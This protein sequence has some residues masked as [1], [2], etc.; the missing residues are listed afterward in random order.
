LIGAVS[1]PGAARPSAPLR[2]ALVLDLMPRKLGSVER[3]VI[4]TVREARRRGHAI[5]VFTR[6]PVHRAI[7]EQLAALGAA[8]GSVGP[9]ERPGQ[10]I[11]RLR[12]YDVVEYHFVGARSRL[13][14][15]GCA[16][17][18]ARI[19]LVE[20]NS[21]WG[22][23]RTLADRLRLWILNGVT[24]P[25]I[26][27]LIGVSDYARART[28]RALGFPLERTATI[29]NGVD[30]ELFSPPPPP[31]PSP[32]LPVQAL[33]PRGPLTVLAVAHFI[34]EKGID[35]LLRAL[36]AV[37][38]VTARLLLV[39]DGPEEPRLRRLTDELGLADRVQFGGLR[40]D[41][42]ALLR[43]ADVFVHPATWQEAFGW[44]IAEAMASGCA[45]IA[46]SVG[47]IP[48]LIEHDRSGL[49]VPPADP[50]ALAQAI[51]RLADDSALRF[52]LGRNAR[53]RAEER[54]GLRQ[55][56]AQHVDWFERVVR[57]EPKQGR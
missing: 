38:P 29:Y 3:W 18:P 24:T 5:D 13:V 50:P 41:V 11:P 23:Q 1:H 56:A 27:A 15:C 47:G 19:I 54:F 10:A 40:D 51:R 46:S 21:D 42:A 25:R 45:V 35:H 14:L 44:T 28:A 30:L 48:E 52:T 31:P 26:S 20:R 4:G 37:P 22:T 55:S 7:H 2:V 12:R 33:P 34:P 32:P 53:R 39:G 49:L 6:E 57:S 9:L 8:W 43:G 17:W 36:A 16:A